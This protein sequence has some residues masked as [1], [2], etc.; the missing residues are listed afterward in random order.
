MVKYVSDFKDRLMR[1]TETALQNLKEAQG[2]MKRWYDRKARVKKFCVRD[3]VLVL[4]PIQGHPM[5][6]RYHG[7]WE[8]EKKISDVNCLV[9]HG[10][11]KN[12]QLCY[13]NILKPFVQRGE[14]DGED[15]E[16]KLCVQVISATT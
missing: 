2:E 5:R 15:T 13:I 10:N 12:N 8:I 6:A 11:R 3:K 14:E 1:A 9:E 16:E 4:F 7:P